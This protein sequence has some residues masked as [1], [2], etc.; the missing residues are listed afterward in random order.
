MERQKNNNFII[1]TVLASLILLLGAYRSIDRA[2]DNTAS[3]DYNG[4]HRN[5]RAASEHVVV[6]FEPEDALHYTLVH[7]KK[8]RTNNKMIWSYMPPN[9][10][11]KYRLGSLLWYTWV[12]WHYCNWKLGTKAARQP[13]LDQNH[14]SILN[15]LVQYGKLFLVIVE[16]LGFGCYIIWGVTLKQVM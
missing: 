13:F 1:F 14:F 10:R 15:I 4:Y 9:A 3:L 8:Q 16:S 11:F 12:W 2:V 7:E 5:L 6:S